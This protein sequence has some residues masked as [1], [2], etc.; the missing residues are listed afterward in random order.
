MLKSCILYSLFWIGMLETVLAQDPRFSQYFA[1][2]LTLNPAYTGFFEGRFRLASNFRNQWLGVGDPFTTASIGFEGKFMSNQLYDDVWGGGVTA[3]YDRTAAGSYNST[4][5]S[6]S[7]AY[8]KQLDAD[9]Y[10]HLGLGFQGSFG[11]RVLDFNKI[12]FNEQFA[13]R[14][15]D[16]SLPNG[17]NFI[18]RTAGYFDV[19]VGVLYNF[20]GERERYYLGSSLYHVSR[21]SISFLGNEEYVLP[22]RYTVHGGASWLVG[23]YSELYVS[24]QY[25]QQGTAKETVMGLAY[26]HTVYPD[27]DGSVIYAGL[28]LRSKDALYPYLGYRWSDWQVG[29]SYDITTSPLGSA[30]TRN[31]SYELSLVYT[32]P[33]K[34]K[35]RRFIPCY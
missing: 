23:A 15:F 8:H 11:S 13:S 6:L 7:T 18:S 33:G 3:M 21:P 9:G 28:W 22:A 4:Y 32:V 24:G 26:G 16:L 17:E 12:S 10:Q 35:K 25:M 5:V 20:H 2:P 34:E 19:N 29:F 1:S 27:D 30:A 31:R 14:G